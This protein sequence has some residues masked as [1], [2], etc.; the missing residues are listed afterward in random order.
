MRDDA[1][2]GTLARKAAKVVIMVAVMVVMLARMAIVG[3]PRGFLLPQLQLSLFLSLS[4][5]LTPSSW[6]VAHLADLLVALTAT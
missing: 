1:T 2:F 4:L 6:T 3:D 5:S